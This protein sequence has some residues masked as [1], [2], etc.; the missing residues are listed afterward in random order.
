[1]SSQCFAMTEAYDFIPVHLGV[2]TKLKDGEAVPGFINN[3]ARLKVGPGGALMVDA[4]LE[5]VLM[6][7]C[8]DLRNVITQY[9][10]QDDPQNP[11]SL[12]MK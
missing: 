7:D 11:S 10:T 4:T 1:M 5:N 12:P 8:A 6:T 2:Y 3:V 9:A